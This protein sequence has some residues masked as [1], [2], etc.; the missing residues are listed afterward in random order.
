MSARAAEEVVAG[1]RL[2]YLDNLK[3]LLVVGVIAVHSAITYGVDGAWYL[4][5]YDSMADVSV[6]VLTVFVAVGFLFGLG[7]FFLI[8]GRLSGPSLD[9]KG[10]ARFVGDRLV[11]LGIPVLFYVLMIAP[12]MEYVK[13]RDEG[14]DQGFLSFAWDQLADPA[15]GPTWFLEAL[16]VF[17][18]AYALA[19][20]L[21]PVRGRAGPA[22]SDSRQNW[23]AR[24][25][26]RK[27]AGPPRWQLRH[28]QPP[29]DCQRPPT[30]Q[31]PRSVGGLLPDPC[32]S[33]AQVTRN[34]L[35]PWT[36]SGRGPAAELTT[37]IA[38]H[39][40]VAWFKRGSS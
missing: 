18:V 20:A 40:S 34:P 37:A 6:G 39:N 26:H 14:A 22:D 5:D 36:R 19:R 21:W 32:Q 27:P 9:R 31:S 24:G 38:T 1:G 8:A 23:S 29:A 10:P 13:A 7:A 17:S 16:L 2:A 33:G 28:S 12:V 25:R 30:A 11:R 4:E 15:P 3:V 35:S